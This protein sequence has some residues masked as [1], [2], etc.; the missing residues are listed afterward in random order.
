MSTLQ[1]FPYFSIDTKNNICEEVSL[2]FAS[3][4]KAPETYEMYGK[5]T[6]IS[7]GYNKIKRSAQY[8]F[9]PTGA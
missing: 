8:G 3:A 4:D 7:Q 9:D 1:A 5:G 6:C 2:A